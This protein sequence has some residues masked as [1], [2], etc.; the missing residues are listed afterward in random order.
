MKRGISLIAVLMFMLAATTA[1][2]VVFRLIGSENFSSGARL[3][4]TEAY[5]ASESGVDA[6][7]AWLSNKAFE[8][9]ALVTQYEVQKVP[10]KLNI[11]GDI[12]GSREQSF[13][14]F[15]IGVDSKAKPMLK[16]KF[17]VEGT[18]RDG[19]K[20]SQVVIFST[21][22]LYNVGIQ[23]TET[24]KIAKKVPPLFGGTSGTQGF[25]ES[26]YIIGDTKLT[27]GYRTTGD[28]IVTGSITD[29]ASG[30][31]IGCPYKNPANPDPKQ[32][33]DATDYPGYDA[34]KANIAANPEYYGNFYVKENLKG[35]T[36]LF[37]GSVYVEGN[38]N[39]AEG[40]ITIWGDLYVKGNFTSNTKLIVYGNVTIEGNFEAAAIT[41]KGNL[42]IPNASSK[43]SLKNDGI[44]LNTLWWA[45]TTLDVMGTNDVNIIERISKKFKDKNTY[46]TSAKPTGADVL[47]YLGNQI[48]NT[49]VNGKYII[50]D[51]IMTGMVANSWLSL[52]IPAGCDE[53]LRNPNA[54]G[55]WAKGTGIYKGT[56]Y[57]NIIKPPSRDNDENAVKAFITA[58]NNC[59]KIGNLD[60]SKDQSKWL[61]VK[62]YWDE[63][64]DKMSN[65]GLDGNFILIVMN[66]P[67][68]DGRKFPPTKPNSNVLLYLTQGAKSIQM[69]KINDP[70]PEKLNWNYFIYSEGDIDGIQGQLYL[71]GNIFM[72]SGAKI[73]NMTDPTILGNDD[74]FNALSN[75]GVI[76]D[77]QSR[78]AGTGLDDGTGKCRICKPG[79]T[80]RGKGNCIEM[81]DTEEEEDKEDILKDKHYIPVASRLPINIETK[82]IS[83]EKVSSNNLLKPSVLVMPRVIRLAP[84]QVP[85]TSELSKYYRLIPLNGA[86][87]ASSTTP[88]CPSINF[89]TENIYTCTV[90]GTD[91]SNT[92]YV[93][94]GKGGAL[95]GD[96]GSDNGSDKSSSSTE[97][98]KL[99]CSVQAPT[100]SAPT[101][102]PKPTVKCGNT[103]LTSSFSYTGAPSASTPPWT[104]VA[105]GTYNIKVSVPTGPS[106][107]CS[108]QTADC[109]IVEVRSNNNS[110]TLACNLIDRNGT[111]ISNL[112]TLTLTQG[113]NFR[114]KATCNGTQENYP[115]FS[116]D[117]GGQPEGN[118][119][120]SGNAYYKASQTTDKEYTITAS[121]SC[122]GNTKSVS[123][124]TVKVQKPT[125]SI[126]GSYVKG[127]AVSAPTYKCGNAS[128]SGA[129]FNITGANDGGA[130]TSGLNWD[131][132]S[133]HTFWNVDKGRKVRMY[134]ISCDS[135]ALNYGANND[136]NGIECG[137]IDIVEA[138]AATEVCGSATFVE[139]AAG[140]HN[141]KTKTS[142]GGAQLLCYGNDNISK[143]VTYNGTT[144]SESQLKEG[145]TDWPSQWL[146]VKDD[147]NTTTLIV[148]AGKIYCKTDW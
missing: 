26:A 37:C 66:K 118:L 40:E 53:K 132:A 56:S 80:S 140:S 91:L 62:V 1:S 142:C 42:V 3:K 52:E 143:T 90:G 44:D 120:N 128:A 146:A 121:F 141:V 102:I 35:H 72:S 9:S 24:S 104:N 2:V 123:C 100:S 83:K 12:G 17:L 48:T 6:V 33:V 133:A 130:L 51:P 5:Q 13:Q 111:N 96:N 30:T 7:Q 14:A 97:N 115:T 81:P 28:V 10:I 88:N 125:C 58:L 103:D 109:G 55:S 105:D 4:A 95:I 98:N 69:E 27:A 137:S 99:T 122:G 93:V 134:Q 19:S 61:V 79:E 85:S 131:D 148:S 145:K 106:Q 34:Y 136:K 89:S 63:V 32:L 76:S 59:A 31:K 126:S 38:F 74:L 117:V 135:H 147:A 29:M 139:F 18:G 101:T 16:L 124:G 86:S 129:K 15:L 54:T 65:Y 8:A 92:F 22:G 23:A 71:N 114:A 107:Q 70:N 127:T 20:V 60:A 87:S 46:S 75:A 73:P 43:V 84:G 119:Q 39:A 49:K 50:P 47:S 110:G 64:Q 36:S 78:C 68:N 138:G 77:N 82:E 57:P 94:I 116:F 41:I 25:A 11:G 45:G 108:G 144:K 67:G 113:E 112:T 21:N